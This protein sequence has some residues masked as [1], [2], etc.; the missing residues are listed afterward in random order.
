MDLDDMKV[1][2]GKKASDGIADL[3]CSC[4]Y[5]FSQEEGDIEDIE[6]WIRDWVF[7]HI[8]TMSLEDHMKEMEK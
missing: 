4:F 3:I 8:E 2:I 5:D 7:L 6:Q 1:R